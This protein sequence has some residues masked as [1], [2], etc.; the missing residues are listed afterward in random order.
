MTFLGPQT[1]VE[2]AIFAEEALRVDV[3]VLLYERLGRKGLTLG[4]L[5]SR[6]DLSVDELNLQVFSDDAPLPLRLVAKA[7]HV[8][9]DEVC[10]EISKRA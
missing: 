10:L 3:Q 8:I 9:G 5:A 1:P 4:D 7:F 2:E 6:L